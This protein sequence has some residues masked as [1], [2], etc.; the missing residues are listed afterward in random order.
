MPKWNFQIQNKI[1]TNP[2]NNNKFKMCKILGFSI[3]RWEMVT[4]KKIQPSKTNKQR[5]KIK[6]M[7]KIH[8]GDQWE[9]IWASKISVQHN[10]PY[11]NLWLSL[12]TLWLQHTE[13]CLSPLNWR[14][15]KENTVKPTLKFS[16]GYFNYEMTRK[17]VNGDSQKKYTAQFIK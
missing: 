5:L 4:R 1:P 11:F 17:Y 8:W 6:K 14:L 2:N 16:C 3:S 12:F 7:A 15:C 9:M 10:S 13:L